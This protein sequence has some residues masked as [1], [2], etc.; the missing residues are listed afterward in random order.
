MVMLRNETDTL[1]TLQKGG[2]S[3]ICSSSTLLKY[4]LFPC[5]F[6][7]FNHLFKRDVNV[8]GGSE[9]GRE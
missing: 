9:G 3:L 6:E 8:G 5:Y 7:S 4:F 1:V 2:R